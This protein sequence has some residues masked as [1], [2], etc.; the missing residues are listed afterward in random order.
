MSIL[1]I[2]PARGGS[3]DLKNKNMFPLNGKPLLF[4]TIEAAKKTKLIDRVIVSS[5]SK[6]ILNFSKKNFVETIKRPKK[7]SGSKSKTH[8][9]IIHCL[10]YLKKKENYVPDIILILQPT[11]P[12]RN[13]KHISSAIKIFLKDKQATS[14]VSCMKVPHNFH[15]TSLMKENSKGYLV[16]FLKERKKIYRRQDKDLLFARNGA[17]IYIVKHSH[18]KRFLFGGKIIK[19]L[20]NEDSSVDIDSL[21]DVKKAEIIL[22]KIK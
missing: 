14:L 15:P 7:I 12:L 2:I 5:D 20:M 22:K 1:A 9:A 13:S 8:E 19:F 16:D 3:V 4:Y 18:I 17:G 11:S 6:K 10:N 21:E